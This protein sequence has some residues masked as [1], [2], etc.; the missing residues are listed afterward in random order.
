MN[1][2]RQNYGR[3]RRHGQAA[4][5]DSTWG[6]GRVPCWQW[7]SPLLSGTTTRVMLP[8][9]SGCSGEPLLLPMSQRPL[10]KDDVCAR[11]PLFIAMSVGLLQR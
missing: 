10:V 3:Q 9:D 4:S 1:S 5:G 8:I 7:Q 2:A 6:S 11:S